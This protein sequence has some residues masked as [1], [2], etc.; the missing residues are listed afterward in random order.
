M[1]VKMYKNHPAAAKADGHFAG[2]NG[3]TEVVPFQ[4]SGS[5]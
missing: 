3:T 2:F 4:N 1:V 5:V